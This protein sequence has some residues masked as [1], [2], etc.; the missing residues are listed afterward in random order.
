[1]DDLKH[2]LG[3]YRL[4]YM[5]WLYG[6][7]ALLFAGFL[8]PWRDGDRDSLWPMFAASLPLMALL[9]IATAR[10]LRRQNERLERLEESLARLQEERFQSGAEGLFPSPKLNAPAGAAEDRLQPPPE[11]H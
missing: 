1:M 10:L 8:S 11:V 5:S 2:R 9:G 3:I 6:G 7:L 4:E